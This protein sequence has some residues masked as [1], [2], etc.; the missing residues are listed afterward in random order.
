M[1]SFQNSSTYINLFDNITDLAQYLSTKKRKSGRDNSSE[2]SSKG[3]SGTSSYEEAFNL[4]KY[5]D[6]DLYKKF[7]DEKSKINIDKLLGNAVRRQKYV[8]RN[9]G[10]VPNVPAYLIGN[11]LNMINSE[12]GRISHKVL[13]IFLSIGVPA[14]INKEEIT[15]RG[16]IYLTVIDLLEKAGYR[17]NVYAGVTAS[18]GRAEYMYVRI[19]TDREPLNIKKLA[20]PLAHP[21]MLRRIYFKWAEVNDY[22]YDIT[23]GYGHNDSF[24]TIKENMKNLYKEDFLLWTYVDIKEDG[25]HTAKE[26]EKI[27]E[28]L[29]EKGIEIEI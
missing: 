21:S 14:Y 23:G 7:K 8:N 19:K 11:P 1:V 28:E 4:F 6:D 16:I 10:C 29:K 2:D 17:C 22:D 9:Y 12:I 5:G 25:R 20:F 15:R 27:V 13:N 3:F 24:E 18:S 26:I